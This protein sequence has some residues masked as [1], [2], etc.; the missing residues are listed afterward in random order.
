MSNCRVIRK[1]LESGFGADLRELRPELKVHLKECA[2]CSRYY[3]E[4]VELGSA[5]ELSQ[6]QV[7][8]GELDDINF[9]NIVKL[10][11]ETERAPE[12]VVRINFLRWAWAPAAAAALILVA[13]LY[14]RNTGNTDSGNNYWGY[15][16]YDYSM[17]LDEQIVSSDSLSGE[18]ISSLASGTVDFEQAADELLDNSDID[19]M[20]NSLTDSELKALGKRV[21]NLKG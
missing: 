1:K 9:E 5:L 18:V 17:P 3:R 7:R 11:G 10:A 12:K 8:P 20:L 16:D 4:L 21:D 2:D 13:L 15:T 19:D 14:P 6:L